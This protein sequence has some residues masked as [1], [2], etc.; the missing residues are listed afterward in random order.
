MK[1]R[2]WLNQKLGLAEMHY[3][4]TTLIEAF[5]LHAALCEY[6]AQL[7][8]HLIDDLYTACGIEVKEDGEW[9]EWVDD[10]GRNVEELYREASK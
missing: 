6:M 10:Q 9:C 8:R 1:Y 2:V 5:S 7:E 4:V 3:P